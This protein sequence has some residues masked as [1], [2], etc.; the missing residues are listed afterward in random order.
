M[1][2]FCGFIIFSGSVL[3][4][5][6]LVARKLKLTLRAAS[7]SF[8]RCHLMCNIIVCYTSSQVSVFPLTPLFTFVT[9]QLLWSHTS[10]SIL[11]LALPIAL[12]SLFTLLNLLFFSICLWYHSF[13]A[14]LTKQIRQHFKAILVLITRWVKLSTSTTTG[15][16]CQS[17]EKDLL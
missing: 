7:V 5:S 1:H 8:W 16:S 10:D 6:S 14:T 9:T 11:Q 4:C 2:F 12:M 15:M 13:S 3:H 17:E